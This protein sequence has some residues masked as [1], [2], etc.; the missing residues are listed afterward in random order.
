MPETASSV[1]SWTFFRTGG[2]DQ[3]ALSSA[4]DL[5]ALGQLDQKLWVA[6]SCPVKGLELDERTLALIDTDGDGRIRVPELLAA[7]QWAAG[8]LNDAG[9]S[10]KGA[11]ALPLSAI[12]ASTPAGKTLLASARQILA[13]LGRPDAA[14]ISVADA[15]N[16]ARIFSASALHGDGVIPPEATDDPAVQA[17]IRDIIACGGGAPGRNGSIGVTAPSITAFFADLGAY[18]SWVEQGARPEIAVL[19]D[20][21]S[22]A[23]AAIRSMRKKVEDYFAR[24]RLAAFDSRSLTALNRSES[25]YV[26]LAAKELMVS[27]DEIAAFP[28]ARIEA[29]RPLPLLDG[30]NPAWAGAMATLHR[31]A[32]APVFG[33]AKATLTGGEWS[34]LSR[35]FAAHE[36]WLEAKAGGAVEKLGGARV[37]EILGGT[38]RAALDR[39]I[40]LDRALEPEFTAIGEVEQLA[41]Y[42]RDLRT[43]LHNFVNFADFYSRDR[44]AV[45]QAGTLYLDSRS[46][47]LCVRVDAPHPLAAMSKAYIAY[48]ACTRA[49]CAPMNIAACFTQGDSDY[50]FVGRHGVFYDRVGRDWDAVITSI[51][52]NPISIRQAFWSPY[53]KFLRMVEEQV[54]KRAAAS[55]AQSTGKL[56]AAAE[57]A[58]HA[59][60]TKAE[61]PKKID[62]GAVAAIGVAIT[63]AISALTLILGYVFQL[64]AWQYP[65]AIAGL[66]LV[67]S[68]PSMIIAWLKLRQR[69]LGPLL[70]GNG[71][72][73]NGRVAIN[74]PFGTALT[75][76]AVLPR[77]PAVRWTIPTRTARPP[78]GNAAPLRWW[79]CSCWPAPPSS[80]GTATSTAATSGSRHPR[81]P[82]PPRP[83]QPNSPRRGAQGFSRGARALI[84]IA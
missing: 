65:L 56:S 11:E 48:C 84:Q 46:T 40:A 21:T 41:R 58:A 78:S 17:L 2:L 50:L 38:G 77:A 42:H 10:L 45:F 55:E 73:V 28:L 66:M 68:V 76:V 71:W 61:P 5:L 37:R 72:A 79:F 54:A 18:A 4:A 80:A 27:A 57:K 19:G 75:G 83:S 6:L 81:G 52:D 12:N 13:S 51:T 24:A 15:A 30:I 63:G 1:H 16:P 59:D 47:E 44:P 3:V 53:K 36:A 9:D 35:K 32:V 31:E 23:A 62:V 64:K 67:I 34:E 7:V 20:A 8:R 26:A 39:L 29:G 60:T 74:L 49:G 82:R 43:L 22:S 70:E 25:D 33:T 14:A 69:T